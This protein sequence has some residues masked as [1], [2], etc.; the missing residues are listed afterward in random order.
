MVYLVY[1]SLDE[2]DILSQKMM[3]ECS[4]ELFIENEHF[5]NH[6]K[7]EE[8]YPIFK[9]KPKQYTVEGWRK[10]F[11]RFKAIKIINGE[12][13]IVRFKDIEEGSKWLEPAIAG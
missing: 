11:L 4:L 6:C 1:G 8:I 3:N 13:K 9:I 10:Q 7:F 12:N 5:F 2:I